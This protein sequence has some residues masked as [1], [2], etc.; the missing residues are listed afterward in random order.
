LCDNDVNLQDNSFISD[1]PLHEACRSG[2]SN[3][4]GALLLVGADDTIAN[5]RKETPAQELSTWKDA[6]VQ[7]LA[8]LDVSN[9]WKMLVRLYRL[10]RHIAARVM[11]TLIK[12]EVAQSATKLHE[13]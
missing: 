10:R 1:T 9:Q 5:D 13:N 6:T 8:L 4:V 12:F 7:M 3:I 11:L 2:Y